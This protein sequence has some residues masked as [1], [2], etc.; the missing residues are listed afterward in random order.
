ML[1]SIRFMQAWKTKQCIQAL[2][3]CKQPHKGLHRHYNR[4]VH[5]IRN[6]AAISIPTLLSCG[7]PLAASPTPQR[8]WAP[9]RHG[10]PATSGSSSSSSRVRQ[11]NPARS[12]RS[13]M[14]RQP[15]H[16]TALE[17][18][19]TDSLARPAGQHAAGMPFYKKQDL[20]QQNVARHSGVAAT[21]VK[22]IG[23]G[24]LPCSWPAGFWPWWV[25]SQ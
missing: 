22:S 11:C 24:V 10:S 1:V 21:T 17:L 18:V 20:K 8:C 6:S 4:H 2:L 3:Q 14:P 23:P 13:C 5:C 19:A 15:N 12:Y 16:S 9:G 7:P 25:P